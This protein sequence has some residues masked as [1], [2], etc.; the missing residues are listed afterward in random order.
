MEVR[1]Q[2]HS[3]TLDSKTFGTYVNES[4]PK[5]NKIGSSW[6]MAQRLTRCTSDLDTIRTATH[7][8]YKK[9]NTTHTKTKNETSQVYKFA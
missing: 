4:R 2:E 5:G 8:T 1:Y 9:R 6:G 3:W 7:N